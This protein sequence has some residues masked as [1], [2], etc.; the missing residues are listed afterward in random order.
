MYIDPMGLLLIHTAETEQRLARAE[1]RRVI[2]ERVAPDEREQP[3]AKAAA[4]PRSRHFFRKTVEA[5]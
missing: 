1:L 4:H 3:S 5:R 2:A